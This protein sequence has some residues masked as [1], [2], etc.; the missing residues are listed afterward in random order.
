MS[1]FPWAAAI[2]GGSNVLG[3]LIAGRGVGQREAKQRKFADYRYRSELK[4]VLG[5]Q[6]DWKGDGWRS[7]SPS[8]YGG[9]G[10]DLLGRDRDLEYSGKHLQQVFDVGKEQGLTPQEIAGSPA[11]GGTGRSGGNATLGQSNA[12]AASNAAQMHNAAADRASNERI[13]SMRAKT[14]LAVAGMQSGTNIIG[15]QTQ[16]N[17]QRRGQDVQTNIANIAA[18]AGKYNARQIASATKYAASVSASAHRYAADQSYRSSALAS[19]RQRLTALDQLAQ[20][21]V[22]DAAQIDQIAA[23]TGLALQDHRLKADLHDERWERLFSTMSSENVM[24]SAIAVLNGVDVKNVLQGV[25][26][27]DA[28]KAQLREFIRHV[29]AKDSHFLKELT[30]GVQSIRGLPDAIKDDFDGVKRWWSGD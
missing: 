5:D 30:G 17:T 1:G 27:D 14:E 18:E 13:A 4:T 9:K 22:V 6:L 7:R 11:A 20:K 15:Q 28:T 8:V 3:G 23:Q 16:A 12:A 2:T 25:S 26:A 10:M 29:N 19:G 21:K 24:A